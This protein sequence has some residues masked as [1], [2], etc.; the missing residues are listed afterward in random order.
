LNKFL[1]DICFAIIISNDHLC[2][3]IVLKVKLL[4]YFDYF[5]YVRLI[6]PAEITNIPIPFKNKVSFLIM[7]LS[8]DFE[9][10]NEPL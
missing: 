10:H 7:F 6:E 8:I 3:N 9:R 5:V 4:N 1:A 2:G